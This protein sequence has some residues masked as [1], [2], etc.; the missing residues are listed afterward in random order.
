MPKQNVLVRRNNLLGRT[1]PDGMSPRSLNNGLL[2]HQNNSVRKVSNITIVNSKKI[3]RPIGRKSGRTY[4]A[5]ANKTSLE[6]STES[7]D[8]NTT[9]ASVQKIEDSGP[10]SSK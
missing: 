1:E 6:G 10:I 8:Q 5:L 4:V 3:S 7:V 9:A 2:S